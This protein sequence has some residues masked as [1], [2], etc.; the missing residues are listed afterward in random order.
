M[1]QSED[2]SVT[3]IHGKNPYISRSSAVNVIKEKHSNNGITNQMNKIDNEEHPQLN[4]IDHTIA[5]NMI[6]LRSRAGYTRAQLAKKMNLLESIITAFETPDTIV[7]V[8]MR[9]KFM[10]VKTFLIKS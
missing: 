8:E 6:K 10:K 1:S 2:N 9:A 4:K 5:S 3:I 7:S